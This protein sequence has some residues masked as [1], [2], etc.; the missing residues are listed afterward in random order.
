MERGENSLNPL[1]A[2]KRKSEWWT[3]VLRLHTHM[4]TRTERDMCKSIDTYQLAYTST[5]THM[6]WCRSLRGEATVQSNVGLGLLGDVSMVT[7]MSDLQI[8]ALPSIWPGWLI[9]SHQH[10]HKCTVSSH[11]EQGG[12]LN[13]HF[14]VILNSTLLSV[15]FSFFKNL[16]IYGPDLRITALPCF[17]LHTDRVKV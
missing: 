11:Y 4:H 17:H 8:C 5:Y 13:H 16:W 10:T 9:R 14:T 6:G 2:Q 15:C 7:V 3:N 1:D 12:F